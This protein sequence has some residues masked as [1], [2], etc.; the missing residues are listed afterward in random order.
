MPANPNQVL[1]SINDQHGIQLDSLHLPGNEDVRRDLRKRPYFEMADVD[2]NDNYQSPLYHRLESE[3]LDD[4]LMSGT[5]SIH[6]LKQRSPTDAQAC[7]LPNSGARAHPSQGNRNRLL[8]YDDEDTMILPQTNLGITA[9][10]AAKKR[11]LDDVTRPDVSLRGQKR[12]SASHQFKTRRRARRN[13]PSAGLSVP[14]C[15]PSLEDPLFATPDDSADCAA[16]LQANPTQMARAAPMPER[17]I[18][19]PPGSEPV[20]Y[21][22]DEPVIMFSTAD[23][24]V[25]YGIIKANGNTEWDHVDFSAVIN[26]LA[27]LQEGARQ[28]GQESLP[29]LEFAPE[30][31]PR[32]TS[33]PL[34]IRE[35]YEAIMFPTGAAMI[36]LS[37]RTKIAQAGVIRPYGKTVWNDLSLASVI[38]VLRHMEDTRQNPPRE[39]LEPPV[40]V[41]NANLAPANNLE[42][43]HN[44]TPLRSSPDSIV[45]ADVHVP[46][47][48]T[49]PPEQAQ[50]ILST[51]ELMLFL[52]ELDAANGAAT[53]PKAPKGS[54]YAPSPPQDVGRYELPGPDTSGKPHEIFDIASEAEEQNNGGIADNFYTSSFLAPHGETG[55]RS[56]I[57]Y[58]ASNNAEYFES[59]PEFDLQA[60]QKLFALPV[61]DIPGPPIHGEGC[62]ETADN[63]HGVEIED[64]SRITLEELVDYNLKRGLSPLQ[65]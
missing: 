34:N 50:R 13:G 40:D 57:H 18:M 9:S 65:F 16:K 30:Q 63:T 36:C 53:S 11:R 38:D 37:T 25:S 48:N 45:Y 24:K 8:Q 4:Q 28:G 46:T 26:D 32:Q 2:G 27:R 3:V 20:C 51:D 61:P 54:T 59:Y 10:P 62:S 43:R 1:E 49:T 15:E 60:A 31:E 6:R 39:A 41:S 33:Y 12:Y 22:V 23:E 17:Q 7:L 19:V 5:R 42:G 35:G 58:L 14:E 64:R 47:A 29:Q 21:P 44:C 52:N 56:P 55:S